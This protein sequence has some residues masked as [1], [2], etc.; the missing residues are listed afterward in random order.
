MDDKSFDSLT[1]SLVQGASRRTILKRL[2]GGAA[3]GALTLR[4]VRGV[5]ADHKPEHCAKEGQKAHPH[6]PCCPG[7][8]AGADERCA[9]A[10]PP[11][12]CAPPGS[13]CGGATGLGCCP[14]T[15]T[16][17][18]SPV[19]GAPTFCLPPPVCFPGP[20]LFDA[21]CG[22]GCECVGAIPFPP[23]PSLGTCQAA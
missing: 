9:G 12:P 5:A 11:P 7:L 20:C 23:F 19:P 22:V 13:P 2:V 15:N 8:V 14:N 10:P 17:C 21:Q 18:R 4:G 1:R 16:E 3:A 6:K